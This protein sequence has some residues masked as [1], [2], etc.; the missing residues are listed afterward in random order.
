MYLICY[1]VF[2]SDHIITQNVNDYIQYV[3]KKTQPQKDTKIFFVSI[4]QS[5]VNYFLKI[6][7]RFIGIHL[8][9][10]N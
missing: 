3:S 5:R 7:K 1:F 9:H 2:Y 4:K 6:K 8:L 10:I